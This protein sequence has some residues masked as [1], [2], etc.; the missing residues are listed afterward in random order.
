MGESGLRSPK[1]TLRSNL[2]KQT[3]EECFDF[4]FCTFHMELILEMPSPGVCI[5]ALFPL[6]GGAPL[7]AELGSVLGSST[8]SREQLQVAVGLICRLWGFSA[9]GCRV[10]ELLV[11]LH[12][13]QKVWAPSSAPSC[14]WCP[15]GFG[16]G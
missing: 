10:G 16:M 7:G 4:L 1:F 6:L 15:V 2:T 5:A 12:I 11:T 9:R 14:D 8:A 3:M 13:R